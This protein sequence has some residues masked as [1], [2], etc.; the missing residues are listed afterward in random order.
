MQ[1]RPDREGLSS[2]TISSVCK[3]A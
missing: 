1:L 2:V 3:R